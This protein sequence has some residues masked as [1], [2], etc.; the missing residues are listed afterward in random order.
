MISK[1]EERVQ[2]VVAPSFVVDPDYTNSLSLQDSVIANQTA[3][4]MRAVFA[5]KA[6]TA[7]RLAPHLVHHPLSHAAIFS[8]VAGALGSSG[9]ANYAAAN[10]TLDF[11]STVA[12][13]QVRAQGLRLLSRVLHWASASPCLRSIPARQSTGQKKIARCFTRCDM[14]ETRLSRNVKS[15]AADDSTFT[16]VL[17]AIQRLS[18]HIAP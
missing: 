13:T 9:Q 17:K 14:Y 5:P 16:A 1:A 10:A 18:S 6:T 2:R 4:G 11:W 12:Q 15:K 8:S 7:A 3:A